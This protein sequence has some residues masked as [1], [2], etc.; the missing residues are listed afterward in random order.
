MLTTRKIL[1]LAVSE[2]CVL[3]AEVRVRRGR[4]ELKR[5]AQLDFPEGISLDEPVPLGRALGQFLRQNHF[6][7]RR[8]VVGIPAKWLII[9]QMKVPPV[10][11]ES[12]AR[13]LRIQAER[14]F[15]SDLKDLALDYASRHGADQ[16]QSVLVVATRRRTL[17]QVLAMAQVARLTIQS[18]TSSAMALASLTAR[19]HPEA[20]LA[21]YLTADSAE[22]TVQSAGAFHLLRRLAPP[23]S[24]PSGANSDSADPW[25]VGLAGEVHRVVSLLPGDTVSSPPGELFIWDGVGL[26]AGIVPAL[27]ER[28]SLDVKKGEHLSVLGIT[29]SPFADGPEGCRFAAAAALA[30][31][32]V[33]PGLPAIDFLHPRLASRKKAALGR[34]AVWATAIAATLLAACLA[35]VL[36]WQKDKEEV[37]A[38]R[39]RLAAMKDDIEAAKDMVGKVSFARGW[40]D[41]RPRF[42][43]CMRELTLRFPEEGRIW[44]T[45]FALREDARGL[46]SGKSVDETT[47][48]DVLDRLNASGVFSNVKPLY[49]R[50]AGRD[51]REVSFAVSF[52]FV[53]G[54]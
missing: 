5:A 24:C 40:C 38:L 14:D 23:D 25:A 28:L 48:L 31:T 46:V 34:K 37:L 47:V 3:A 52:T 6:S 54:E 36:D 44:I 43:D 15:S 13:I 27:G 16:G 19:S 29:H 33:Q 53:S 50:Q 10:N 26:D 7:A 51:S 49:M 4:R 41:T 18:V 35:L 42:L 17:D 9:K 39:G 32:G 1:G 30:L 21:L 20:A 12:T 2:R 22:L 11:A 45:N 8:A